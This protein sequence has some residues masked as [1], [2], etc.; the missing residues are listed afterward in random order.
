MLVI[1]ATNFSMEKKHT[2]ELTLGT[3]SI[4]IESG[5]FAPQANGSVVASAGETIVLATAVRGKEP[6]EGINY[7]P[8]MVDYEERFYAAGKILGGRFMKRE[9]KSSE[10]AVLNGRLIDRTLRPLFNNKI[11]TDVQIIVTVLS[12]D[13]KNDPDV[14]SI[15]AASCALHTSDIQWNGPVGAV[16][17]SKVDESFIINAT[18]EERTRS[19]LDIV[20]SGIEGRVNMIEAGAREASEQDVLEAIRFAQPYIKDIIGF[21]NRIARELNVKK[22]DIAIE[23]IDKALKKEVLSFLHGKL[24]PLIFVKDKQ[25]YYSGIAELEKSLVSF[26]SELFPENKQNKMFAQELFEE[27]ISRIVHEQAIHHNRR[28][29]GRTTDE[30]RELSATVGVLPRAHGSAFFQ[31]GTT[32]ALSVLTLG[33]PS[34]NQLIEGMEVR[35][36]KRFMH[37]YNFPPYSVGEVGAMRGPGRRE[38]GHGALA[39]KALIPIIPEKE[40]FPY[41]IRV[42]SEILSSNG[43]SS[44]ASVCGATLALMDGGVPITTPAAGI[45]MGLMTLGDDYKILTDLQGPEDHYGDMDFKV[46]GTKNGITAIQLDVKIN[47]LTMEMIETTLA[48][49]KKARLHILEV[50]NNALAHARNMLSPLAPRVITLQIDPEKIRD[51]IGP[52]GKIINQIIKETGAAIDIDDSGL[53]FVTGENEASAQKAITWISNLTRKLQVGEEFEGKVSRLLDF[54]AFVELVGGQDG[55][56]HAS[57]LIPGVRVQKAGDVVK[58][59]DTIRVKIKEIDELGR[60]NLTLVDPGQFESHRELQERNNL[61]NRS[62]HQRKPFSQHQGPRR[63]PHRF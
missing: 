62:H 5:A 55:L 48:Q 10:E 20:V 40:K 29:D 39:E 53:V 49:A 47:G 56:L 32:Q 14:L 33:A 31:R 59:G 27:E 3:T 51:V 7:F 41:T 34:D 60:I 15:I 42:V 46:A 37:H 2:F 24:E 44:M 54:G 6:R 50:M 61:H 21:Q 36:E 17:V 45:A 58:I 35:T 16:R 26:I 52:Q 43:S 63:R 19:S 28:P 12:T 4:K 9:G 25:Q 11:R 57:E 22:T 38:I 18:F 8:L 13:G 1:Q 30:I 23:H